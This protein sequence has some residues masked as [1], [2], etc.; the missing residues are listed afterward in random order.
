MKHFH[1]FIC[2]LLPLICTAQPI[3]KLD[4]FDLKVDGL[5]VKLLW[6]VSGE[7]AL[8]QYNLYRSVDNN[9]FY[10][11]GEIP[12]HGGHA[13]EHYNHLDHTVA[14]GI[15]Y[16]KL[17]AIGIDNSVLELARRNVDMIDM[18]KMVYVTPNVE[19]GT[20]QLK[21]AEQIIDIEMELVDM[22]GRTFRV[23][24]VRDNTHEITVI[25]G[26]IEQGAYYLV[27]KINGKRF[28]RVKTMFI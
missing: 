9:N 3:V 1:Y 23:S 28:A 27:C 8:K 15:N 5:K 12:P 24:F 17:T 25:T 10:L 11:I 7:K 4:Y 21:S 6:E 2:F 19:N 14:G 20:I 22:L 18:D 13:R 26:P 16:Y